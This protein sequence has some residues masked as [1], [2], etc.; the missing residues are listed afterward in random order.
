[1][2]HNPFREEAATSRNERQQLDRLLR[3]TAPHERIILAGF[4]LV[5][6]GF[7]AWLLFG[8]VVRAVSFD[9]ALIEPG[10]RHGVV[11][12][13]AGHL[14]EHLVVPGDRVA[15]GDLIA[16]QSVPELDREVE[17][18]R[19]RVD[20]LAAE[21]RQAGG[22]GDALRSLLDSAR[23]ALLQMEAR[24]AARMSIVSQT[25]GEIANLYGALGDYMASGTVVALL[26]EA[27]GQP[28]RAV[29]RA[30]PD[31]ARRIQPGM[32]ASVEV[33][34]PD[35]TTQRLDGAV[36]F[37]AAGPLPSWLA[38]LLPGA[39]ESGYRIDIVL[40]QAPALSLPDGAPCRIRIEL[41]RSTPAGLLFL[42]LT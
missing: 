20:L 31:M 41:G 21:I 29:L 13:E 2:F 40:P 25:G 7:L 23:A 33:A 19:E 12:S 27:N 3:I 26:R 24:R 1:M 36:A 22:E 32:L 11:S 34:M 5:L 17:V 35:G 37:V 15:A 10:T 4:G 18:L 39:A 38:A 9:G 14:L 6:V 8:S 28:L 30:A 16:R 42:G